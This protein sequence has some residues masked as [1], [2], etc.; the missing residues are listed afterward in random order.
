VG[1]SLHRVRVHDDVDR[2]SGSSETPL[3]A[4][5]PW[6]Q[7]GSTSASGIALNSVEPRPAALYC[8]GP[9]GA[10]CICAGQRVDQY[11]LTPK[12]SRVQT[13]YRP[14]YMYAGRMARYRELG[15]GLLACC[16]LHWEQTGSTRSFRPG[17][18]ALLLGLRP[19]SGCCGRR[20]AGVRRPTLTSGVCATRPMSQIQVDWEASVG[21]SG[22]RGH[23]G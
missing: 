6:E 8:T 16:S 19:M 21:E 9:S 22:R 12:R 3:T 20:E 15:S 17:G 18:S 11:S 23:V 14:P 13:Q 2:C 7:I 10:F 4:D 1:V 5:R